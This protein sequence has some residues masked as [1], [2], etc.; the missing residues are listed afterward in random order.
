MRVIH[1]IALIF[2]A[3]TFLCAILAVSGVNKG[4]LGYGNTD[5]GTLKCCVG[6]TCVSWDDFARVVTVC[7]NMATGGKVTLALVVI[8][9]VVRDQFRL[10]SSQRSNR[11][12][13]SPSAPPSSSSSASSAS[14]TRRTCPLHDPHMIMRSSPHR[15][16]L[17]ILAAV[18]FIIVMV[19]FI[20]AEGVYLGFFL[21][22]CCTNGCNANGRY[23]RASH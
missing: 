14:S 18:I 21:G 9:M 3:L 15:S 4:W 19:L 13:S 23:A 8:N 2:A 20:V 6:G 17:S 10:R 1:L 22:D 12:R 7:D 11:A 16:G 5:C